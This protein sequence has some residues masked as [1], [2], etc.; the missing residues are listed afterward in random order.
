MKPVLPIVINLPPI[1][2]DRLIEIMKYLK[3]SPENTR[4][5]DHL[6]E[7]FGI[8]N[9]KTEKLINTGMK[10]GLLDFNINPTVSLTERGKS[11]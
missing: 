8:P 9:A 5:L 1:D 3:E 7:R 10:L 4:S 2:K 11:F 6:T